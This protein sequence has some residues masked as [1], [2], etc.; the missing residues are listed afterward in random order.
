MLYVLTGATLA[1]FYLVL[2]ALSEYLSFA[3]SFLIAAAL[4]IA[5][6]TPYTG[7]LLGL[8]DS[9]RPLAGLMYLI[10]SVDWYVYGGG[11]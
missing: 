7:V 11:E 4:L 3:S 6:V 10:R 5:I 1:V 8:L 9:R 2:L